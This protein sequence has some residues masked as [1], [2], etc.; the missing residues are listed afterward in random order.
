MILL[1]SFCKEKALHP[2]AASVGSF[3][4]YPSL[5]QAQFGLQTKIPI[6]FATGLFLCRQEV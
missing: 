5:E 3:Y 6:A 1:G 2:P 4:F